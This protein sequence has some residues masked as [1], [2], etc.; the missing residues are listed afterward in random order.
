MLKDENK[1]NHEVELSVGMSGSSTIDNFEGGL[2]AKMSESYT[3]LLQY[4]FKI[5]GRKRY[6]VLEME[7]KLR[8]YCKKKNWKTENM[9]KIIDRLLELK[10]LDDQQ[11]CSDYVATRTKLKPRGKFLLERELKLKGINKEIIQ[12][13]M[14][15]IELNE[16]D[17]A[18]E[19][20]QRKERQWKDLSPEKK[21]EKAFRFL[22]SRGFNSET[23]YRTL[24]SC[25]NAHI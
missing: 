11:Y 24:N 10:Y 2:L 23:I 6:T 8:E 4:A 18:L 16:F 20:L 15:E 21:R 13:T 5:L 12:Q 9:V 14:K 7:K 1:S 19:A 25:Y 22:G 17:L 3:K